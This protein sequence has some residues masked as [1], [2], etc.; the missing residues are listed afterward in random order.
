MKEEEARQKMVNLN[1]K[2]NKND[3]KLCPFDKKKCVTGCALWV[4]YF[5][6][7]R[8]MSNSFDIGGGYCKL[9]MVGV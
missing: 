2:P 3:L 5:I 6:C 9:S 4:K 8:P 7:N 1:K